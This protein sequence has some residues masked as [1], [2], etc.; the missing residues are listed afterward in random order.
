MNS[1][2]HHNCRKVQIILEEFK[3]DQQKIGGFK[4]EFYQDTSEKL[5]PEVAAGKAC[6]SWGSVMKRR[7]ML[8]LSW[9]SY[10]FN[11]LPFLAIRGKKILSEQYVWFFPTPST[12]YGSLHDC[13]ILAC[14]S[15]NCHLLRAAPMTIFFKV[16]LC[17][18]LLSTILLLS[19]F[20]SY[21]FRIYNYV[22]CLFIVC[23]FIDD[24][25]LKICLL[26]ILSS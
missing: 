22:Y 11:S 1:I 6:E 8:F 21:H 2:V 14:V 25:L 15:L 13:H 7:H 17:S 26:L 9:S 24:N 3:S 23:T 18:T 16:G 4:M 12:I 10:C 20:P 5:V 19:S